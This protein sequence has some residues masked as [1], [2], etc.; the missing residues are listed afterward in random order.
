MSEEYPS[1]NINVGVGTEIKTLIEIKTFKYHPYGLSEFRKNIIEHVDEW[2][3]KG[4]SW[5]GYDQLTH[6]WRTPWDTHI[7]Y[8]TLMSPIVALVS[9]IVKSHS[10]NNNW[11]MKDCWISEYTNSS[12][13]N[14]HN[15]GEDSLGWSFC[16]YVKISDE[17]PGFTVCDTLSNENLQLNVAE[18]DLLLFRHPMNHQVFPAL[19]RRIIISGNFYDNHFNDVLLQTKHFNENFLKEDQIINAEPKE[20]DIDDWSRSIIHQKFGIADNGGY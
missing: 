19:D 1:Y 16:Y 5:V 8:E 4:L 9:S 20:I 10:P 14:R 15:H 6:A 18:G 3:K 7:R 13:A 17:G 2:Q 11:F 12:G